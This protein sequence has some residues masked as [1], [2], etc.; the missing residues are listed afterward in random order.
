MKGNCM[1]TEWQLNHHQFNNSTIGNGNL[2]STSSVIQA[3]SGSKATGK[4]S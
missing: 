3:S 4:A 1:A 2:N